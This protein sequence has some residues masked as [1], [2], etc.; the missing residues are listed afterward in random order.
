MVWFC[1]VISKVVGVLIARWFCIWLIGRIGKLENFFW[2]G[3]GLQGLVFFWKSCGSYLA[4]LCPALIGFFAVLFPFDPGG[5]FGYLNSGLDMLYIWCCKCRCSYQNFC[6][7]WWGWLRIYGTIAVSQVCKGYFLVFKKF[8]CS[9]VFCN[10]GFKDYRNWRDFVLGSGCILF[11]AQL[12]GL[13]IWYFWW[14]VFLLQLVLFW[15]EV[16]RVI[17]LVRDW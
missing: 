17:S 12:L 8:W 16:M 10:A 9:K 2:C 7:D 3:N 4:G 5:R 14:S 15:S 11:Y 13:E 6:K 1:L